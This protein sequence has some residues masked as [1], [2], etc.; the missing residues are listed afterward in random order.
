MVRSI[1]SIAIVLALAA[2]GGA[3]GPDAE[4]ASAEAAVQ[5]GETTP[6]AE[7]RS[8]GITEAAT[9]AIQ[10]E[11]DSIREFDS[12]R[13]TVRVTTVATG[14][15]HPW[16][17]AFLPDGRA[18]VT[19]RPGRLRFVEADGSL[20]EPLRGVPEVAARGQ[21]GLL[22]VALSPQF[23]NDGLV[24]LSY[25][26]PGDGGAGTSV[27]RGQL[28]NGELTDV[29]VIFRQ[30]P[31]IDSGHHYGSRLVFHDGYL[32]ITM[33]DRGQRPM[34]QELDGHQGTVVRI[35][36][37]GSV[38]GD[39]PFVGDDGALDE[40][41]S[42][43][44]RNIQGAAVNPATGSLWT[45]EHGPRG[46]D[47]INLPVP[48]GNFGWPL[49]THGINYSGEPIP[50][51]VGTE[52]EGV[53]PAHHVWQVS[54]AVSG[55]AFYTHEAAPGWQGNVFIGALVQTSLIRLEL[56]GEQVRHEERL[57]TDLGRRIRDV[58]QGPDGALYLLTDH[59]DGEVL[60]V[61]LQARD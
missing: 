54:P 48:G 12:E 9:P 39:N 38:P 2:C 35:R 31:K 44:H 50:E 60:R 14:L 6:A 46:G 32:F 21:G 33:G 20:S 1:T 30:T 29:Q 15:E 58:R 23:E 7:P 3:E 13:G 27:A 26:E 42:Y 8:P 24:Y 19:E 5:S 37:D 59:S 43:G 55:M 41:W 10:G 40:I 16:G 28:N 18:L 45:H 53:I 52:M 11:D 36:P 61:A 56:D 17:L 4:R 34:S 47:E 51:A 22:D 49:V 57:L 25:S